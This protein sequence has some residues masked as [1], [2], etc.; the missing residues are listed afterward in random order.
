[1]TNDRL[2]D[3]VLHPQCV[4][5]PVLEFIFRCHGLSFFDSCLCD[6]WIR[7][8]NTNYEVPEGAHAQGVPT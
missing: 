1:L 5:T 3:R 7:Y 2:R 6:S 8:L 4:A